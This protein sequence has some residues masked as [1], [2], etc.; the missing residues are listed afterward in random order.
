[1]VE[2]LGVKNS[3][4]GKGLRSTNDMHFVKVSLKFRWRLH[5]KGKRVRLVQDLECIT[6]GS[7]QHTLERSAAG[8]GKGVSPSHL[9]PLFQED[10]LENLIHLCR[11][12]ICSK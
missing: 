4:G 10:T 11:K 1:M 9:L 7:L 5:K 8:G 3:G 2:S 12:V 6:L